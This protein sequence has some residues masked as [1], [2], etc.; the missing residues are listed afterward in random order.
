MRKLTFTLLMLMTLSLSAQDKD[1]IKF[2]GIPIDGP[3]AEFITKL[4]EKGFSP[5]QTTKE[6]EEIETRQECR[7]ELKEDKRRDDDRFYYMQGCFNG[8]T[9]N[10]FIFPYKKKVYM[11]KVHYDSEKSF[12]YKEYEAKEVFRQCVEQLNKKYE[13]KSNNDLSFLDKD[14][15]EPIDAHYFAY[16]VVND[17]SNKEIGTVTLEMT[18]PAPKEF[19]IVLYYCNT[20]NM[21]N[22]EDF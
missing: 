7:G 11:I 18:H 19:H 1:V 14:I 5:S 3:K 22:G 17:D 12:P 8:K 13:A 4:E 9:S 21:P 16:Y 6:L 10:V 20:N 15:S 2:M